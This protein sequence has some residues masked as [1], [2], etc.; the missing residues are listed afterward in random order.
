MWSGLDN[1]AIP[2]P[3]HPL[4]P[5]RAV[6]NCLQ[7]VSQTL[8]KSFCWVI[9]TMV[10]SCI[11]ISRP[12]PQI[13]M[14]PSHLSSPSILS[15]TLFGSFLSVF[16]PSS[17]WRHTADHWGGALGVFWLDGM[18][19][20]FPPKD[21]RCSER[22]PSWL[23]L[24]FSVLT[25][26]AQRSGAV[27]LLLFTHFGISSTMCLE[28]FY[29]TPLLAP[30]HCL[31]DFQPHGQWSPASHLAWERKITFRDKG[32]DFDRKRSKSDLRYGPLI[33]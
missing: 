3:H 18:D 2:T 29:T 16:T 15:E 10:F 14:Q 20:E 17:P 12:L 1:F 22:V 32:S 28:K 21:L 31:T 23:L 19:R 6:S 24:C 11:I 8:W 33:W 27:C 25:T 9:I 26:L 30:S 7:M 13:K 4:L 5:L